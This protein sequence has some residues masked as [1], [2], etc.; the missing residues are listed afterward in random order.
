M[1]AWTLPNELSIYTVAEVRSQWLTQLAEPEADQ[2]AVA[3]DGAA[4]V[5]VDAAGVQLLIA[6]AKALAQHHRPL[7]LTAP[8]APLIEAC[9]AL[10][11]AP[12]LQLADCEALA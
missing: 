8:S 9:Q 1:L 12:L 6:L 10:G 5:R 7:H 11:A 3:L 2:A 4:V